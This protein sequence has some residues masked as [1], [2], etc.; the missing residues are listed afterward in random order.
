MTCLGIAK[1]SGYHCLGLT[2]DYGQRNASELDAAKEMAEI[3]CDL[4]HEL[5]TLNLN[6]LKRSALINHSLSLNNFDQS[7]HQASTYVPARNTIFFAYALAYAEQIS[8]QAIFAGGNKDDR[9]HYV[10]CRPEFYVALQ[11][12]ADVATRSAVEGDRIE[13]IAP[14]ADLDK[15]QIILKTQQLGLDYSMT[16]SCYQADNARHACGQCQACLLRRQG[17]EAAGIPDPT[18]YKDGV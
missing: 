9:E 7:N 6:M 18:S 15:A 5:V 2:F 17:F 8:A 16:V 14:L 11:Q 1:S 10:D 13:I 3:Y 4:G 12:F